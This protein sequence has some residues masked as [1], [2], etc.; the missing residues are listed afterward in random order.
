MQNL[1]HYL[2]A[3]ETNDYRPWITTTSAL[4]FFIVIVWGLR[5]IIPAS[6]TLASSSLSSADIMDRINSERSQ[7]FIPT[8]AQN[9]KLTTAAQSKASDMLSRSYFSH[10]DPDGNYVWPKI[11]ASGY[12]PYS[13]LG[14]N[15]AMDFTTPDEL[16]A[17]W[18]NSPTHRA[19]LLND[20][21]KDQGLALSSG[22]Y[23]P[24]HNS[25]IVVSLFGTLSGTSTSATSSPVVQ[26]TSPS[27]SGLSI[28]KDA[29][30]SAT[31]VSGHT[32]I[33]VNVAITGK[34]T[35]ATAK[36]LTQSITLLAQSDGRYAGTFTFNLS[37][38]LSGQDITI[39]ARDATNA[40]VTASITLSN[41][42]TI[43]AG[44]TDASPVGSSQIPVSEQALIMKILR[45]IFGI[46]SIIYLGFLVIDW[47]IMKRA[48]I[49]RP[50]MHVS[51]Q[52]AIFLLLAFV[53]IFVRF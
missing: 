21:F 22:L 18:M 12:K 45:I 28:G 26:N 40:K 48:H 30:V 19:N 6:L 16:I 39:E 4:V 9:A 25:T 3:S 50:G 42:D 33:D 2:I 49:E 34:P 51:P 36:L 53:N 7:R 14:E 5:F 15:L 11:E 27:K 32:M 44:Q 31:Q 13:T 52:I 41:I 17:A 23:E 10:I 38:D 37:E 35:L 47:V 43:P 20:K 1:R 24:D 29:Q 8:V 46:L